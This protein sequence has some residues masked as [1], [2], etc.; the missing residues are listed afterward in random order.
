MSN[1][2]PE[3]DPGRW[4]VERSRTVVRDRWIDLRADDCRR[5]DGHAIAPY[6]VL[7]YA[8]WTN[9]VALTPEHQVVLVR[10]YRHALGE[11]CVELPG[12]VMD[13][14]EADPAVT[15]ARELREET[16]YTATDWTY[17]G[18]VPVNPSSHTNHAHCFFATGATRTHDPELDANEEIAVELQPLNVVLK[19]ALAG[20]MQA[21]HCASLLFTLGHHGLL[22]SRYPP[23]LG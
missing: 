12:G 5:H 14:D 16:G 18:A 4:E 23:P 13:P 8:D 22:P 6:Y 20:Q 19:L 10:L 11:V 9:V 2:P 15:V 21:L 1:P 3:R 17:T 7:R